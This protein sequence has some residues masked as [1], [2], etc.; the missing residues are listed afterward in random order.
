MTEQNDY[1]AFLQAHIRSRSIQKVAE[2]LLKSP[3]KC[4]EVISALAKTLK[5][6]IKPTQLK[7]GRPE[8]ELTESE[9]EWLRNVL[10]KPDII[11][12]PPGRKNQRYVGKL[13]GKSQYVQKRYLMRALKDLLNITKEVL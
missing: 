4:K 5:L 3:R 1:S 6:R 12:V 11:Y 8:N 7:A 13:N 10:D 9:K 2:I